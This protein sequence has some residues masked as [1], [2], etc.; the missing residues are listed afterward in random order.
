MSWTG[1]LGTMGQMKLPGQELACFSQG[2]AYHW[3]LFSFR[4]NEPAKLISVWT[5]SWVLE[6]EGMESTVTLPRGFPRSRSSEMALIL[7]MGKE[8]RMVLD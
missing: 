2:T 8:Q 5:Y 7:V 6:N 4:S 3:F 1:L